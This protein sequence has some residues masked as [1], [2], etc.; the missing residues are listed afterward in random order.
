MFRVTERRPQ[1]R[2][3]SMARA[4]KA[5]IAI[6]IHRS[7]SA[8]LLHLERLSATLMEQSEVCLSVC[9]LW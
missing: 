5:I 9:R 7:R 8:S 1:I 4:L 6:A 3:T 2:L